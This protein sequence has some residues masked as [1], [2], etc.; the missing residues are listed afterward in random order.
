MR[1][2]ILAAGQGTRLRPITDSIPKGLVELEGVPILELVL[3][4]LPDDID[5]ILIIRGYRG[6]QLE[7]RFGSTVNGRSV[8]YVNQQPLDG[9]AGALWAAREILTERAE[10]FLVLHGDNRY[11]PTDLAR[12]AA[13]PLALGVFRAT[14]TT[15]RLILD[16]NDTGRLL[17]SHPTSDAERTLPQLICT[18]SYLLDRQLF[19]TDPVTLTNGELGLPQTV[20][21]LARER[22]IQL[23]EHRFWREVNTVSDLGEH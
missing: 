8:R 18:G 3:E 23:F 12:L 15:L 14:R 2:I 19:T 20:I 22:P 6:D 4:A 5:Q 11:D 13:G 7:A 16:T 10:S 9:T 21:A 17:G 1:A